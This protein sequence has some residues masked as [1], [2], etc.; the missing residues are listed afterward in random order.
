MMLRSLIRFIR[1]PHLLSRIMLMRDLRTCVR[2]Y[3]LHAALDIG[4]LAQLDGPKSGREIVDRIKPVSPDYLEM[5]LK[6]GVLLGE[7]SLRDGMYEI[8][9]ARSRCLAAPS[10]DAV[11]ALVQEHAGYHGWVY[12][13]LADRMRGGS[14][15]DYLEA[16]APLVARSSRVL[17]PFLREFVR[18]VVTDHKPG[19]ILEVGC[20]SGIYLRH[21]AEADPSLT[22]IGIDM[23]KAVVEQARH[24]LSAWGMGTRFDVIAADIRQWHPKGDGSFDCISLYNNLY[25]FRPDERPAI[26]RKL[27]SLLAPGGTLALASMM[28]GDS[29]GAVHFDIVLRSTAGCAPLPMLEETVAQLKSNGFSDVKTVAILPSEQY[30]GIVAR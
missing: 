23:Q 30:Y 14:P 25:Y 6:L 24:N 10:G 9:G 29:V 27:R 21:A 17:E 4:L 12:Q 15:G 13:G 18:A 26:Y 7:V 16:T 5:L 22:G 1:A 20:G 3:F 2:L 8:A 28:Q 19:T 11:A